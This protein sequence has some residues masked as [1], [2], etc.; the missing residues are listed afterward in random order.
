MLQ[1]ARAGATFALAR[2][3]AATRWSDT[4]PDVRAKAEA[5]FADTLAVIAAGTVHS[6]YRPFVDSWAGETGPCTVIGRPLG[7]PAETAALIN[8]GATM[9][10]QWQD[11][12]RIARGHPASHLVPALLALAETGKH[13]ADAVMGAF[14][15]GYEVSVRIGAALG[16]MHPLLHDAGTFAT[17]GAAAA[18]AHLES[19]S[20]AAAIAE[21]IEVAA[22]VCPM[23]YRQTVVAGA[24][25]H[26]L[27][28]GEGAR[29][30]LTT[31][32]AARTGLNALGG[33]LTDFF[34]PRAG[35]K[36][37]PA[38]LTQSIGADGR[39]ARYQTLDGYFKWWPVCAHMSTAADAA[40]ALTS[41]HG[42]FGDQVERAECAIYGY[43]LEYNTDAP[44]NDF[45]ARFS[46]PAIVATILASGELRPDDFTPARLAD[47][48][49]RERMGRVVAV[50]QPAFDADYPASRP[51]RLTVRL[52]DGRVLCAERRDP[53]GDALHPL[54]ADDRI[55]KVRRLLAYSYGD[56]GCDR[57]IA[58][59]ND[60]LGGG[61]IDALTAALRQS[62]NGG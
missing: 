29:M 25:V 14:V 57:V 38:A 2:A 52:R 8:G 41:E 39:W 31:A 33:T 3:A 46:I 12:H 15:A 30:A 42:A 17:V 62:S 51:C 22:A 28:I 35:E 43:A 55:A 32:R 19:N 40:A 6:S 27:Y 53:Y 21:A 9:V 47:V 24:A 49:F 50:H 44:T 23:P 36:F 1:P 58:R 56:S 4:P 45:A 16:G 18:A 34:G 11:G 48:K 13:P 37:N 20:D 7:V 59:L 10:L 26:Q 61:P 54:T 5:L 60:Y